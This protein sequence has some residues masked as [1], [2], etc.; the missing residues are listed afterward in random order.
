MA[1]KK[2]NATKAGTPQLTSA[3]RRAKLEAAKRS[4]DRW[5]Q[6]KRILIVVAI[7]VAIVIGITIAAAV[8]TSKKQAGNAAA[9]SGATAAQITPP[10]AKTLAN[11]SLAIVANPEATDAKLT[12]DI[13]ADYQCP[14]CKTAEQRLAQGLQ[15]LEAQNQ[16]LVQYHIRSFLDGSLGNTSS[17][18]AAM[19]ATCADTVGKFQAYNS[20]VFANQPANEGTG[21]TNDQL[22][23]TF[24]TQAGISGDDLTKFQQCYDDKATSSFV[25]TME[26]SNLSTPIPGISA[27]SAG[28]RG[29]PAFIINGKQLDWTKVPT[30]APGMLA[31]LQQTANS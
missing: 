18:Q 3:Q 19:A 8:M 22:R 13:H 28:V 14:I 15:Q 24:A 21:Y 31:Y 26:Q 4:Q 25:T 20:V 6:T 1:K 7:V 10:N 11:G 16:V 5:Q 12:L 9:T 27:Y 30:D 17:V 23:S 29:T 2:P